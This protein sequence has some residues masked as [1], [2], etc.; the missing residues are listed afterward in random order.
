MEGAGDGRAMM[1]QGETKKKA[2]DV[3]R[4][5][6]GPLREEFRERY[7]E[8]NRIKKGISKTLRAKARTVPEISHELKVASDVVLWHLMAMKRYGEVV[9][10]ERRGA[11]YSYAAVE[12]PRA[13]SRH[14]RKEES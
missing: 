13:K 10:A 4:E 14:K 6:Q 8:S 7:K 2:I 5:R 1:A 9:E 12:K 11:Y 3:L